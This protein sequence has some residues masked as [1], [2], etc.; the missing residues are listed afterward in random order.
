ML[1]LILTLATLSAPQDGITY[2]E[3]EQEVIDYSI[4]L[5]RSIEHS[6]AMHH[7]SRAAKTD[8]LPSISNEA[9]YQ[10]NL[11][12]TDIKMGSGNVALKRYAYS[13]S[14]N[15]IQ[16]I[17]SGGRISN[18]YE[19]ARL[20]AQ[21][22]EENVQQTIN[23]IVHQAQTVYWDAA[24]KKATYMTA[25]R[26]IGIIEQ[27]TATLQEK[28][29]AGAISR[30]DLLQMQTRL[31]EAQLQRSSALLAYRNATQAMNSLMGRQPDSPITPSDSLT[32]PPPIPLAIDLETALEQRSDY[33]IDSLQVEYQKR[34]MNLAIAQHKPTLSVGLQQQIATPIINTDGKPKFSPVLFAKM[35][36]PL[37]HWGKR[38]KTRA[39]QRAMLYEA[40]L[41]QS[42]KY[43]QVNLELTTSFTTVQESRKQINYATEN[44]RLAQEN[45][46]INTFS[47]TEGRLTILDVLSAQLTWLQANTSLIQSHYNYRIALANYRH[48]TG[49]N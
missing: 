12:G 18:T 15:I 36:M 49:I 4:T 45:L 1:S 35:S 22:A 34:Q 21:M 13:L 41:A 46:D 20:K 24:V 48:A 44:C 31:A 29:E 26:Y 27:L 32:A 47:Y 30:T 5:S 38:S 17:L 37:F 42:D 28:Y 8:F 14:T 7:A 33:A 6:N 43:D 16:P 3:F 10:Y 25:C 19:A 11:S 40:V 23:D 39:S 9:S 2:Q